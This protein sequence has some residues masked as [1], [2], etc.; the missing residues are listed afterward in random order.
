MYEIDLLEANKE[1]II[2]SP[3]LN[4]AKVN[5]FVRLIK[6]RQENGV[7]ITV[8]TLDPE[9]Y[10]EEKIEDTKALVQVLEN[11]GIKVRLQDYMHEHFAIIDDEIVWYG[12]MNLLSR[13]KIDDNLMRVKSKDAAQELL[14]MTFG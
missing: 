10:P 5:A 7:K 9:G 13:A 6:Q 11:C 14:E 3:G 12:S 2:S 8:V 1:V 4:Q